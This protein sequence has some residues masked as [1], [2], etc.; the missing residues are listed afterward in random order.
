MNAFKFR[1]AEQIPFALD[2]ILKKRLYCSDWRILN[3]PL[4][5]QFS[6]SYRSIAPFSGKKLKDTDYFDDLADEISDEKQKKKVCSLS[7]T[8]E[9]KL[10]W[11]HYASG[12]TGLAIEVELP[13]VS[14]SI[15]KVEYVGLRE[16]DMHQYRGASAEVGTILSTKFEEWSYEEE[17][18]IIQNEPWFTLNSKIQ[19]VICGQRM[20][21]AMYEALRIVCNSKGIPISQIYMDHDGIDISGE[22]NPNFQLGQAIMKNHKNQPVDSDR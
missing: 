19:R 14:P 16:V 10:L 20:N 13:D 8:A 12:F 5:G 3:D 17:I 1:S 21:N 11:A 4:E 22:R 2:I 9:S 6:Y 18:R 7:L 15:C